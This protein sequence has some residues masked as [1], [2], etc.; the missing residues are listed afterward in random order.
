MTTHPQDADRVYAR[1]RPEHWIGIT[2]EDIPHGWIDDMVKRLFEE[3]NRQMLRL[4]NAAQI[5]KKEDNTPDLR[6]QES[7]TLARLEGTLNRL[8][9]L[10]MQRATVRNTKATRSRR[11]KRAAIRSQILGG[12]DAG[13]TGGSEGEGQ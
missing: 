2:A 1:E 9:R 4:E 11:A 3:L 7:L 13:T 10:D 8:N 5:E 6:E 12:H